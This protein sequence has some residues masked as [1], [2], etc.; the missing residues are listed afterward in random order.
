[1]MRAR[2]RGSE[3]ARVLGSAEISMRS[4]AR[5]VERENPGGLATAR[6]AMEPLPSIGERWTR[7]TRIS[8]FAISEP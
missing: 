7:P 8:V 3:E 5:A 1:M 4:A 6:E 2:M